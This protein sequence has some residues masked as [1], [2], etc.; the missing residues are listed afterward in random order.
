MK[1][2]FDKK[3]LGFGLTAF[4]VI[5]ASIFAI[6]AFINIEKI[7]LAISNVIHILSPILYGVVIAYLLTP[8][9]N[10]FHNTFYSLIN[11]KSKKISKQKNWTIS[12]VL[13]IFITMVLAILIVSTIIGMIIPQ[14]IR[15]IMGFVDSLPI[16]LDNAIVNVS[17]LLEDNPSYLKIVDGI[18]LNL[19]L[20]LDSIYK[21][22]EAIL[23]SINSIITGVTSS[24]FGILNVAKNIV[25]GL[26]VSIYLL[27]SKEK[28]LAQI[29]KLLYACLKKDYAE[30]FFLSVK[31]THKI[32]GGFIVGKILDSLIIGILCF[33]VMMIFDWPF[34]VLISVIIG[35]TNVIPFFGPFIGAIPSA[36]IILLVEPK[37]CLYFVIFILILQQFDGNIL[38]PKILGESTGLSC[39]WVIFSILVAGGLFGF[40]GM[41][42]GVPCF[43]VI[44]SFIKLLVNNSLKKKN[45]PTDTENYL[46][47]VCTVRN[48]KIDVVEKEN[49]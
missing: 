3:Y 17:K 10:K 37:T 22:L 20:N 34:A 5:I 36:V 39:F 43:A 40:V 30:N 18:L 49:K 6:F 27:Y 9:V 25:I 13:S 11:K 12:R 44:Y 24:V 48:N 19:K 8:S 33:I 14:L 26:I 45:M 1:L 4:I 23:P 31:H 38:G 42:V 16:Y 41:V 28:F 2:K 46:A 29:K 7:S 47:E 15:S 35:V 32:F 21:Q